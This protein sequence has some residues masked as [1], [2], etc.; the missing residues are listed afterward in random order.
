MLQTLA[1]DRRLTKTRYS[2]TQFQNIVK[3]LGTIKS[4]DAAAGTIIALTNQEK[5]NCQDLQSDLT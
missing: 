5:K 4:E 2:L 3:R 1:K